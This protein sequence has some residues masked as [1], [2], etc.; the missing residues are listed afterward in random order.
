MAAMD[1]CAG[2]GHGG[3]E[4]K[5]ETA[6]AGAAAAAAAAQPAAPQT[7]TEEDRLWSIVTAN[8][9]DFTSWTLLIQEAERLDVIDKIRRVYDTFLAEFPLCYGYWKK[10]ADHEGRHGH[11]EKIAEVYERAV[12]GVT[13]S[14]DIWMHYCTFVAEKSEDMGEIRRL[15]ER[16]LDYVGTDYLAHLL[17]DKY[18][19]FEY[20]QEEWG[21][22][23]QLYTRI[24]LI[25]M[26]QIDRY[27]QSFKQY[28]HKQMQSGRLLSEFLT[29]ED[30]AEFEALESMAGNGQDAE[31]VAAGGS[32]ADG[33]ASG[34]AAEEKSTSKPRVLS[35]QEKLEKY[36]AR[37]DEMYRVTKEQDMKIHD[38][39]IAIRRPYFHV[40]PLDEMQLANWHRYLDFLE[41][42]GNL[43]KVSKLYER[44]L[45]ACANYSEYWI[46]YVDHLEG[47]GQLEQA[48]DALVR[49]ATIFVKRRPE[50][51]LYA[52][53]YYEKH[54]NTAAARKHYELLCTELAV[55]LLEAVLKY[56]NLERRQG[57]LDKAKA[58]F[59]AAL[60]AEKSKDDPKTFVHLTMQYARFL[61]QVTRNTEKAREVFR[62]AVERVPFSKALWQGFIFFETLHLQDGGMSRVQALVEQAITPSARADGSGMSVGDREEI[63]LQFLELVDLH[64]DSAAV[65]KAEAVHKKFFPGTRK[66]NAESS[67]K[68]SLDNSGG[69]DRGS[70][71]H[72][73]AANMAMMTAA[74]AVS[75]GG[76]I[77][78]ANGQQGQ[79]GAGGYGAG[80]AQSFGPQ[81][82]GWQQQAPQQAAIVGHG[83]QQQQQWGGGYG[84]QGQQTYPM[85]QQG[86]GQ[87]GGQAYRPAQQAPLQQ[88]Q[89]QQQ[90]G[91]YQ[92]YHQ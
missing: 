46:R 71:V 82:Q 68:R 66:G 53:R 38:Y 83:Q 39:E 78:Y 69:S 7:P 43:K 72:K 6:A 16:G 67:K 31:G 42:E 30:I 5:A 51:H 59:E 89:Q 58:V 8:P 80:V 20:S 11:Q 92:G 44:C 90:Q 27:Y 4:M 70:K 29:P 10:Y 22:V 12:K 36:L 1:H 24:L 34:K 47:A 54:E 84:P 60:E 15:F 62:E 35:E 86:Y 91:Y 64:G 2:V 76:Q 45:I 25:P 88:Q 40:K 52:A 28:V 13:Y 73:T 65:R 77:A 50:V 14:V 74:N 48:E 33:D 41:K 9:A 56:A 37:R 55:G 19:E 57:N 18:L 32:E 85:Q 81:Q 87:G 17:W 49:A 79:W 26:Q 61:D 23:A 75:M 63:S 21:R 3:G